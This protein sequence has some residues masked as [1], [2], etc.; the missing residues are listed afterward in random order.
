MGYKRIYELD[1]VETPDNDDYFLI[2][3]TQKEPRKISYMDLG[4][5]N[6]EKVNELGFF[7]KREF[8]SS[9]DKLRRLWKISSFFPAERE[10]SR[11]NF[12]V[13][14]NLY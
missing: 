13:Y 10:L 9:Y 7:E 11:W 14:E 5:T 3:A 1:E 6:F 4:L 12:P 8:F 2:D